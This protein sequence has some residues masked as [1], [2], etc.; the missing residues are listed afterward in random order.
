[1]TPGS[2]AWVAR[3][4]RDWALEVRQGMALVT[5]HSSGAREVLLGDLTHEFDRRRLKTETLDCGSCNAEEFI[6][7]IANSAADVL[8]VLD[9]DHVLLGENGARSPFWVN[10]HRETLVAHPG[11]QFWWMRPH[12]ATRFGQ[13]LPDL[14]RFFLFRE[15]LQEA[16][17]AREASIELQDPGTGPGLVD[18]DRS[19]D[20]F[21]RALHAA[22]NPNADPVRIWLELG[23]P[24]LEALVRSGQRYEACSGLR[25][26]ERSIGSVGQALQRASE[27]EP[28]DILG[29]A[30]LGLARVYSEIGLR[31][32][33][34]AAAENSVRI[35][36]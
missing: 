11:V 14:T 24:A 8:F 25:E 34:A 10:F 21:Q 13:Q 9:P 15:A 7:R 3:S 35:Y 12:A 17:P 28:S 27:A 26:L 22:A 1:M 20:L 16:T 18:R 23:I 29:N 32:E 5:Y 19:H 36:R 30:L 33:A 2:R 31:K 4:L 6:T